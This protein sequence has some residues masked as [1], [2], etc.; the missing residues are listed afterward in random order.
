MPL[1]LT[2]LLINRKLELSCCLAILL[3]VALY[4]GKFHRLAMG[5]SF[6]KMALK[7]IMSYQIITKYSP[8]REPYQLDRSSSQAEAG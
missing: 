7:K 2:A 5:R 1:D 4:F 6:S 8:W 3:V